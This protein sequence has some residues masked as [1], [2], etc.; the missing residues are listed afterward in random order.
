MDPKYVLAAWVDA[1]LHVL[2]TRA[3]TK[4]VLVD[5]HEQA[6]AVADAAAVAPDLVDFLLTGELLCLVCQ[7]VHPALVLRPIRIA[8]SMF[9]A[10]E[11]LTTFVKACRALGIE[12]SFH[13]RDAIQGR[14]TVPFLL[15]VFAFARTVAARHPPFPAPSVTFS[16][17]DLAMLVPTMHR[18]RPNR[19]SGQ[20][21]LSGPGTSPDLSTLLTRMSVLEDQQQRLLDTVQA[22]Q[23]HV[24]ASRHSLEKLSTSMIDAFF[25]FQETMR[26]AQTGKSVAP[27]PVS[28]PVSVPTSPDL[29][30]K[31]VV[32][33][34]E[35]LV[36][37]TSSDIPTELTTTL[38][39]P[40]SAPA[41]LPPHV[42]EA[43]TTKVDRLRQSAIYELV[44]TERDFV[45]DIGMLVTILA[46]KGKEYDIVW[47]LD[48]F[49]GNLPTLLADHEKMLAVLEEEL[50]NQPVVEEPGRLFLQMMP[51][52]SSHVDYATHY[53]HIMAPALQLARVSD[54]SAYL[55]TLP[56]TRGHT[57]DSLL[58]KPIQRITKY[59]LLVAETKKYAYENDPDYQALV[60]ALAAM[61]D[62]T[63]Q[64]DQSSKTNSV[65]QENLA[66]FSTMVAGFADLDLSPACQYLREGSVDRWCASANAAQG[67]YWILFSERLLV[68]KPGSSKSFRK[69]YEVLLDLVPSKVVVHAVAAQQSCARFPWLLELIPVGKGSKGDTGPLVF[70]FATEQ[71]M[72][73]WT[74]GV[75]KAVVLQLQKGVSSLMRR[76]KSN[77]SLSMSMKKPWARFMDYGK[78][79]SSKVTLPEPP[80]NPLSLPDNAELIGFTL[81]DHY[82]A[83]SHDLGFQKHTFL[84]ITHVDRSDVLK[85]AMN[86]VV[87]L[88][89][90]HLVQIVKDMPPARYARILAACQSDMALTWIEYAQCCIVNLTPTPLVA[91]AANTAAAVAAARNAG[92]GNLTS[93]AE[94]KDTVA[95]RRASVVVATPL[96]PAATAVPAAP[97]APAAAPVASALPRADASDVVEPDPPR[98]DS[99]PTPA[100]VA[101]RHLRKSGA[102][103]RHAARKSDMSRG[104]TKASLDAAGAGDVVTEPVPG[105]EGWFRVVKPGQRDYYFRRETGETRWE[106]PSPVVAVVE[107]GVEVTVL[108]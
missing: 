46:S 54:F 101:A 2:T 98:S 38:Y 35:T 50:V 86:R 76:S 60:Q 102:N 107:P 100:T 19:S 42:A 45:R 96:P 73:A 97:T 39:R 10:L 29:S 79:N 80:V 15:T 43:C 65:H 57:L 87:G 55:A 20:L 26:H 64:V 85:V 62:L 61:R 83:T 16:A 22:M 48:E 6:R 88:V 34:Q 44:A 103:G 40:A 81:D 67:T 93:V 28:Q 106:P 92:A 104:S 108:S 23:H 33:S 82:P 30:T 68:C 11:N 3:R 75:E 66:L 71:E 12:A 63:D 31:P 94:K 74:R 9:G 5:A 47:D 90:R 52:L 36:R 21:S 53:S 41:I 77:R 32:T 1:T 84:R 18:I 51:H 7:A 91:A 105:A 37:A 17:I 59:P 99:H 56:E 25:E 49:M 14:H 69:K 95:S 13:P 58:I 24:A 72:Q 4:D 70:G 89:P 8:P 78:T 27:L